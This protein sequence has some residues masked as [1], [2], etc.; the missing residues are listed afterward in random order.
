MEPRYELRK[1]GL[2]I[3]LYSQYRQLA[4]A[5]LLVSF[6][7]GMATL[8]IP[9]T[10]GK[11]YDFLFG[12]HSFRARLL[13]LLPFDLSDIHL[14]MAFFLSLIGARAVLT[15]GE[16]YLI[17]LL[18]EKFVYSLRILLFESQ[19]RIPIRDY[20][21]RGSGR[22][23]LRFSGDLKSLKQYFCQ[24]MIRFFND[25]LWIT[26]SV[27]ILFWLDK[28]L[29]LILLMGLLPI[30]VIVLWLR[31]AL[32]KRTRLQRNRKSQLLAFTSTRLRAMHSIQ[33]F[34][35]EQPELAKFSKLARQVLVS[36]MSYQKILSFIYALIPTLLYVMVAAMF[37]Y[38][39]ISD[40]ARDKSNGGNILVFVMLL[41]TILP[42]LRRI[43]RIHV[44]WELGGISL[45]K[46]LRVINRADWEDAKR[47]NLIYLEGD[48]RL[49][50]VSYAYKPGQKVLDKLCMHL[51]GPGLHLVQ[52][53]AGSGKST[54]IKLI[55][56]LYQPEEGQVLIDGQQTTE[57]NG[58][59]LRKHIA[60]VSSE[61]PLLG[62]K[63]F[64]AISYSR[65]AEKKAKAS[66][67]LEHLLEGNPNLPAMTLEDKIGEAGNRLS[68]GQLKLLAYARALLTRKKIVLIDEP[69]EGFDEEAIPFWAEILKQ[70][71]THRKVIVFSAHSLEGYL[72]P[73]AVHQLPV[74]AKIFS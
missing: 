50:G 21:D 38:V 24:G 71:A 12:M 10:I 28:R 8:L 37:F 72:A 29:G 33:F 19:M 14:F 53:K 15:Y 17:N 60:V 74:N 32:S 62:R 18:G 39:S 44:V 30:F 13:T 55:C 20:E 6:F 16:R 23:L 35:K 36:S 2:I 68:K 65:K 59:S 69:F 70:M 11:Y 63:V 45:E 42:I 49:E 7:A 3:R 40:M 47:D 61:I 1:R 25:L 57:V 5:T 51:Q 9:I 22:Y 4:V 34:N 43:L 73:T 67:V 58:K 27:C 31:P 41:L 46:L 54:L 52:G 26:L 64:E 66:M 56:G 48:I